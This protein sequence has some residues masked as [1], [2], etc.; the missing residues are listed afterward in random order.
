ML[1]F[2]WREI[3]KTYRCNFFAPEIYEGR[4]FPACC[5]MQNKIDWTWGMNFIGGKKGFTIFLCAD[6][7]S[8][9][10]SIISIFLKSV[11]NCW[12]EKLSI[13][14]NFIQL[15]DPVQGHNSLAALLYKRIPGFLRF[16]FALKW[17]CFGMKVLVFDH[18]QHTHTTHTQLQMNTKLKSVSLLSSIGFILLFILIAV[19]CICDLPENVILSINRSFI[20]GFF[21]K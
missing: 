19:I 2:E 7:C 9:I 4:L 15:N 11:Q 10:S 14:I 17:T 6:F 20:C 5:F 12:Y 1:I 16:C 18:L 13:N 8:G 21:R 3:W